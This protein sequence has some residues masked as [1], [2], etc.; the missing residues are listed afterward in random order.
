MWKL[1]FSNGAQ[2]LG[3]GNI[4]SIFS[5][6]SNW[7]CNE[8]LEKWKQ[9]RQRSSVFKDISEK[10]VWVMSLA[11]PAAYSSEAKRGIKK[12]WFSWD[13]RA[14]VVRA[15]AW[16]NSVRGL[17]DSEIVVIFR[18]YMGSNSTSYSRT[19]PWIWGDPGCEEGEELDGLSR[20]LVMSPNMVS[21]QGRC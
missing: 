19:W 11:E 21:E 3:H 5:N 15:K 17:K 10:V 8:V 16:E 20:W 6:W 12:L 14:E 9:K 7:P 4:E 2:Q 18:Y 1:I 13:W